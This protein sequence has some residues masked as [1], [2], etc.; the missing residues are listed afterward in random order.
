MTTE[1]MDEQTS[2]VEY[3]ATTG[4][5]HA[6]HNGSVIH[7]SKTREGAEKSLE[8]IKKIS[9][10]GLIS[11]DIPVITSV[12]TI[13]EFK[14]IT[15]APSGNTAFIPKVDPNFVP[16]GNYKD[17][18][19]II[20]SG[21]FYP[22]Y[23]YGPTGN[24]KSTMVEHIAARLKR[25]VIRI[26]FNSMTDEEALIG[27]KTL[28]DGNVE[29]IEGPL[30]LAMRGAKICLLDEIDAGAPNTLLCLQSILEGKPY[31]FKL[32]NEIIHPAPGFNIIATANT[33]GRGSED[34]K[35]NGTNIQNEAFL[36][37]FAV[38]F[39]QEYP[40]QKVELKIIKKLL[41][42]FS[43]VDEDFANNLSK[44]ADSIRKTYADG[45]CDELITTRRLG[46]I[47]RAYAVYG[48][49]KK[50]ITLCCNRFDKATRDA[51]IDLFNKIAPTAMEDTTPVTTDSDDS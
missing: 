6:I 41:S 45:G 22:T 4:K 36:E 43:I 3:D 50:A 27:S 9:D 48:N 49:K 8:R 10:T 39:D 44:W 18:T 33:K 46:H 29:I 32:K 15:V 40:S 12:V 20:E 17:L 2:R 51:F 28:V 1:T 21:I 11:P 16:F 13:P 30:I 31:Y 23:I 47:V 37:R 24:G 14:A 25:E 34:G 26:N 7:R 19:K 38:T 35:Y 5:F 42:S